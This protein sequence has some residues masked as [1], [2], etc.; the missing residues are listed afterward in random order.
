MPN[1][2]ITRREA[3]ARLAG[4]LSLAGAS[5]LGFGSRDQA[6]GISRS[7]EAIHQE[8]RFAASPARVYSALTVETLFDQV[9]RQSAA[10]QGGMAPA[11]APTKISAS[12]GGEFWLFGGHITGREIELVTNQRIVQAWRS[13]DWP[14]GLYSIAKFELEARGAATTLAFDHTGFP[15]GQAEHLAQGWQENYWSPLAKVLA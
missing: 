8:V 13:A 6:S 9:V 12:P 3:T 5:D 10:M 15:V 11:A 1:P 2:S 14:P 4:W 7:A